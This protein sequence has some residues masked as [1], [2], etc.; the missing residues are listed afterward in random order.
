MRR[1]FRILELLATSSPDGGPKHVWD[2]VRHLPKDEFEP[3]IAAP[4][5]GVLFDRFRD[6]GLRVVEFPRLRLGGRHFLLATRLIS[7]WG[8]DIVHTHGKGPGLYGRLAAR[9][10]RVPAVHTFHGVHYSAYSPLG[11]RIYL[12]LERR[13]S[14]STHTI[15][16]VSASQHAEALGLR[17]FRPEQGVAIVNGVDLDEIERRIVQST[18]RRETLGLTPDNIVI[19]NVSRFD[20]VKQIDLLVDILQLLKPRFPHLIL[21]LVGGGQEEQRIRRAVFERGLQQSVIFTGS[22]PDALNMYPVFDLYIA[23]SRKEG[24]PL[25]QVEAM[26]AGLPVVA[27]DVPGHRDVVVHGE[28]GM[29]VPPGDTG[30]LAEAVA[31]LV[32][33]PA[34]RKAMGESGR[35]RAHKEFDVRGMVEATAQVYRQAASWRHR[36]RFEPRSGVGHPGVQ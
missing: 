25:S 13:L 28:T 4:R 36:P 10:S 3:V 24:L 1:P 18:V 11:Q 2:L 6:L 8:I 32:S 23:P 17:L 20:P 22:L 21:V 7:R 27:T 31:S 9:W 34:R 19:G 29:L 14:R 35:W 30:A 16:N 12:T 33:D 5:D 26:A 15:I